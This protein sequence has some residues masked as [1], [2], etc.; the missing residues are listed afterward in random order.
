M[1]EAVVAIRYRVKG[2]EIMKTAIIEPVTDVQRIQR[3]ETYVKYWGKVSG[4]LNINLDP[5]SFGFAFAPV[6]LF[7]KAS[8]RAIIYQT[9]SYSRPVE[10]DVRLSNSGKS[11]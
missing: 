3:R 11:P 4:F 10:Q 2:S 8:V 1:F 7:A 6:N 5:V 9:Q